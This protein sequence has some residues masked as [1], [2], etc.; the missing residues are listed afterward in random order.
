MGR[1]ED[2]ASKSN[3]NNQI[4]WVEP[5][6]HKFR[7]VKDIT[8]NE[9]SF[10]A[11]IRDE[12]VKSKKSN[13]IVRK[14]YDFSKNIT[15][16]GF[17]S[18]KLGQ[19]L[20]KYEK[21]QI[22][23][24]EI[25]KDIKDYKISQ[26]NGLQTIADL[27]TG[28]TVISSYYL[29][30]NGLKNLRTRINL[31]AIPNILI[32]A[33]ENG[34]EPLLKQIMKNGKYEKFKKGAKEVL[35][36]NKK[37]HLVLVPLLALLGGFTKLQIVQL[38]RLGSKEYKADKNKN[39]S[40][41]E[42]KAQ[43]KELNKA[44]NK[45]DRKA[46]LT[47][48]VNGLLSPVTAI[49]GGIAGVPA[50]I[51]G[52]T[53]LNY[54][55]NKNN[56]NK[57]SFGDFAQKFKDNG[58]LNTLVIGALALPALK[59]ANFSKILK[60]NLDIVGKNLK[61]VKLKTPDLH[62][63]SAYQELEDIMFE[64]EKIKNIRKDYMKPDADKITE[65]TKENIFAVK[66]LQIGHYGQLSETLREN[67]PPT[68][69]IEKAQEVINKLWGKEE[70]EVSK[71]LGV[72]T[73]AETYLAK[74]KSGKEVCIKILKDGIN[75]EKIA[76]DKEK[77]VELIQKGRKI[78]ELSEDEKYLLK[79]LDDLANGISKEVDFTNEMNAA[80]EL[81]KYT[82]KANVVK[83][84]AAKDGIYIME[85]APGISVKTF[86]DYFECKNEIRWKNE[87]KQ[88]LEKELTEY[89]KELES[90]K[91]ETG[92]YKAKQHMI[93][94][95]KQRIIEEEKDIAEQYNKMQAIKDKSPDFKDFD[96]E[97]GH[98][99][100]LCND[101][102]KVV[103][104]QFNKLNREGKV[105]H[106]DIHPG[107]IFVNLEALK[108]GR[109]KLFTLIDTGNTINLSK[110]QSIA[111][112]QL[113]KF[114]KNGN[115]KDLSK[116]ALD[117]AILPKDMT[118]EQAFE[119]VEAEMRKIFF[120]NENKINQMTAEE[121]NKLSDAILRKFDIVPN[122]TQLNLSKARKSSENSLQDLM[123]SFLSSLQDKFNPEKLAQKDLP[124][125]EKFK[126][127][128][129]GL[130]ISAKSMKLAG[131]FIY[132]PKMQ[133]SLNLFKLTPCELRAFLQNPNMHKNNSVEHLT[134]QIKQDM[135]LG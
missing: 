108:T 126:E 14:I 60:S 69:T 87:W 21:G 82:H 81:A 38:E 32:D 39:L 131:N 10:K 102:I 27:G 114:V 8:E 123:K 127:I 15:G 125:F 96:V 75:S 51:L 133:E 70:Y 64:S 17:G 119:K 33:Y 19:N 109:G 85:K 99:L 117:G 55:T 20:E 2:F 49:A 11:E 98:I 62:M 89:E 56:D 25:K 103:T 34:F 29:A 61:D 47:G 80:N 135:H 4:Y 13:G 63:K 88:H 18:K 105:L 104:E 36:S 48:A 76:K 43:K 132:R 7:E 124:K 97:Y 26:E 57:K 122:N 68:R 45:A 9:P 113:T 67:C 118:K 130:W 94:G 116:I 22:S 106:A 71:C 79:N 128:M 115:T 52:V 24:E 1:I 77:F 93:A 84:I 37:S 129:K 101:Y 95:Q 31:K 120:D 58:I 78:E 54:L 50:Y 66:F 35:M 90:L 134:Y 42:R 73:I 46:F 12:Y 74:D 3:K 91:P 53:G 28:A 110:K 92:E 41:K 100:K 44:Q 6:K 23:E 107:N 30:N 111:T 59:H 16:I 83:P 86:A 112:L 65:L 72:G 121:F 5:S 40:K